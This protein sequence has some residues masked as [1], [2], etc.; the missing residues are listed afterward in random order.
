M[1]RMLTR[2]ALPPG[3]PIHW[4][5]RVKKG[6]SLDDGATELAR[7]VYIEVSRP[8]MAKQHAEQLH[9]QNFRRRAANTTIRNSSTPC[10]QR[11]MFVVP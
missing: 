9:Y 4:C 11:W 5:P 3:T 7:I 10:R 6:L 1:R 8:W 2:A